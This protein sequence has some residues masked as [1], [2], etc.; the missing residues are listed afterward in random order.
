LS[1]WR[2]QAWNISYN[3]SVEWDDY[4]DRYHW[5]MRGIDF[6]KE[7]AEVNDDDP[8]L[9]GDAGWFISHKIGRSDEAQ[10]FRRMFKED[11]DFHGT[12]RLNEEERDNWRV[13]KAYY[14]KAERII[15]DPTTNRRFRGTAPL[16]FFSRAPLCE[17]YFAQARQKEGIHGEKSIGYYETAEAEWSG[18]DPHDQ[19]FGERE[20]ATSIGLVRMNHYESK[21][22]EVEKLRA[23][24]DA[25][26]PKLREKIVAEKRAALKPKER[27]ILDAK[28]EHL[29][30]HQHGVKVK[31]MEYMKFTDVDVAKRIP[32]PNRAEAMRLAKRSEK[33]QL[34]AYWINRNRG[35]IN[36][37]Y[38]RMRAK[39][40][41]TQ[42]SLDARLEM[43]RGASLADDADLEKSRDA[44]ELGMEHWRLMMDAYP[45][46]ED[47]VSAADDLLT[48]VRRYKDKVL[49]HLV[50]EEPQ[51]PLGYGFVS[52]KDVADWNA[53]CKRLWEEG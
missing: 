14:R 5:V 33:L 51:L 24:M 22:A 20:F 53:F 16:I 52:V 37:N 50:S 45:L 46:L 48:S 41:Q 12:L 27:E 7:G 49:R 44:Y 2:F 10:H 21:L 9:L 15:D 4:R 39:A 6:L 8:S 1:V 18:T 28:F 3:V 38:W 35:I 34:E 43:Y 23:R 25:F 36:F 47:D 32:K 31:L 13:G 42:D 29:S 40:E 11:E 26:L 30:D 17:F 19:P